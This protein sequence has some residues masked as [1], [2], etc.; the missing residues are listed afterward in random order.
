MTSRA[1]VCRLAVFV[2]LAA[3]PGAARA[4]HDRPFNGT[5][6]SIVTSS[7]VTADGL[8]H[9]E[10]TVAGK[11][12]VIGRLTGTFR[13]DLDPTT[14]AFAG[15]LTKVAANGDEIHETFTGQFN[16]DFTASGGEFQIVDGTGRFEGVT[17]GGPFAGQVTSA[18]TVVIRFTGQISQGK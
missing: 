16:A 6:T 18:T 5:L 11:A 10:G 14:G 9:L 3:A 12:T 1:L 4:D 15:T 13:Y 17:G 2:A 7:S 8:L